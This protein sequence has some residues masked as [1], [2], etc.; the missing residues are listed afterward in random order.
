ML[1]Q[2]LF[3]LI[4]GHLVMLIALRHLFVCFASAYI[5]KF[6]GQ[7][8]T[9]ITIITGVAVYQQPPVVCEDN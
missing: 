4:S 3:Q 2:S 7:E 5:F 9:E 8:L 1:E 6:P